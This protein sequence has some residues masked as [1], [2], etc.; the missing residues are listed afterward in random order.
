MVT[1]VSFF[2]FTVLQKEALTPA[3]VFTG[4]T[5]FERLRFP[6]SVLPDILMD[7]V[8]ARVSLR[9]I[10]S[11]LD[12]DEV[13]HTSN[14]EGLDEAHVPHRDISDEDSKKIGFN[15]ATFK[16]HTDTTHGETANED[17]VTSFFLRDLDVMFPLGE[18]SIVCGSTGSGKTSL[19]L[20][21][22][23][24]MDLEAGN[25][26]L[27]RSSGDNES[28]DP[29]TLSECGVAYVAQTAWL[30]HQSLRENILFGLPYDEERYKKVIFACALQRDLEILDDGD[31][32]EIG[33]Q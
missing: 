14:F 30:Q 2:S 23:G 33:E 5:L 31:Q 13:P 24:E 1:V 6:L 15:N 4:I 29:N 27:P 11:F 10:N 28:M 3:I 12:E 9:R 21:L 7:L 32:T 8:S 17:A 16:W 18:L 19:L 22:L 26:Y 20:A 25:V